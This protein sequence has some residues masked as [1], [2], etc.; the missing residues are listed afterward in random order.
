MAS[1]LLLAAERDLH[2]SNYYERTGAFEGEGFRVEV[3]W[4]DIYNM[5]P[6][7]LHLIRS[8]IRLIS[9]E[10]YEDPQSCTLILAGNDSGK[11]ISLEMADGQMEIQDRH[12]SRFT[13]QCNIR[14]TI[15][16]SMLQ[17]HREFRVQSPARPTGN[18]LEWPLTVESLVVP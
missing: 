13:I 8:N 12:V 17:I 7:K 5:Q 6:R 18:P 10:G 16:K 9:Q 15:N 11:E 2:A 1:V 3:S 14:S 4:I